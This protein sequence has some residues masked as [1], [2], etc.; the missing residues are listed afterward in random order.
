M[1]SSHSKQ[2]EREAVGWQDRWEIHLKCWKTCGSRPGLGGCLFLCSPSLFILKG[3]ALV[4]LFEKFWSMDVLGWFPSAIA[5][6]V[7]FPFHKV[8]ELSRPTLMSM[9]DQMFNLVLF[10]TLD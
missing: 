2:K 1:G 9:V 10:G 5:F 3:V 7:P 6:G 8:L 4:I